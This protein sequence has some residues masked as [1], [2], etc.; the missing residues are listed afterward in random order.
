MRPLLREAALVA[1]GSNLLRVQNVGSHRP[2][3][4]EL[5]FSHRLGYKKVVRCTR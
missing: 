3:M 1:L 4:A 5:E 2:S